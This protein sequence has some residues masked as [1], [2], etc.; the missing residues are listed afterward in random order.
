MKDQEEQRRLLRERL[1]RWREEILEERLCRAEARI[2]DDE[3]FIN[4][5]DNPEWEEYLN[6][7]NCEIEVFDHGALFKTEDYEVMVSFRVPTLDVSTLKTQTVY[8]SS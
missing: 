2:L 5:P 6:D 1:Q 7:P 4:N 3:V 8:W